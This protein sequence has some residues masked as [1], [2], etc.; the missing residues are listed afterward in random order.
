MYRFERLR[1]IRVDML[2][3]QRVGVHHEEWGKPVVRAENTEATEWVVAEAYHRDILTI[4]YAIRR[5]LCRV[6]GHSH[7][8]LY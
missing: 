8:F 7:C 6:I 3:R 4:V 2:L 5:Q 1:S